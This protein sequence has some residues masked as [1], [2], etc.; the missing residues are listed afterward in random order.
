M[1]KHLITGGAGFIGSTLAKSLLADG[2]D[3]TVVDN[4][5]T[6]SLENLDGARGHERF[7]FVEGD[8]CD[9]RLMD[10][11]TSKADVVEHLA[12]RI[13]L[14]IIIGQAH[15]TLQTNV[16]G[17]EIVLEA[18]A[19]YGCR[20]ILASTS[21][22]YGLT[23]R[24]PSSEEDPIVFGSPMKSRWSYACGKALDEFWGLALHR[25]QN[26][27][28]TVVRLFNTVGPRQSARYGMVLPRFVR[29]ALA[30]EPLTVYGDGSQTRCFC[31]V[32]DVVGALKDILVNDATIGELYNLGNP[33]ETT[34]LNLA[35]RVINLTES[36][37]K[38][39]FV[40]YSK[41]YGDGFEEIMRRVPDITKLRAA[42]GFK[43]Q[44]SL[45]EIIRSVIVSLNDIQLVA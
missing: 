16:K 17:T 35:K 43:P 32:G 3:V 33:Q 1:K 15:K 5:E 22:V 45:D 8:I 34:I 13:G 9:T 26:L 19:K 39:E 23:E 36:R 38:I 20:T 37:S 14:Q 44:T 41:A 25:E 18:A 29:Q 21:E 40:P 30:G 6:G 4:L 24:I 27:P 10:E 2:D 11:L 12:A 7:H 28:A 42:I 31:Y